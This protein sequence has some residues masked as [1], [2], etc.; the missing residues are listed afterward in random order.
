M[1]PVAAHRLHAALA[2]ALAA[3]AAA[4]SPAEPQSTR[5]P[6]PQHPLITEPMQTPSGAR[7]PARKKVVRKGA[8][9]RGAPK[10]VAPVTPASATPAGAPAS[11]GAPESPAAP[12]TPADPAAAPAPDPL[13]VALELPGNA[14]FKAW[15]E[16]GHEF[17]AP[18][19]VRS[20]MPFNEWTDDSNCI[21]R[22]EGD[23]KFMKPGCKPILVQLRASVDRAYGEALEAHFGFPACAMEGIRC[24]EQNGGCAAVE[25][26][27][28]QLSAQHGIAV[29]PDR[30]S[31]D[32]QWILDRSV[33]QLRDAA[34]AIVRAHYGTVSRATPRQRLEA[35]TSF[36]QNAVPY[37]PVKGTRDDLVRDG[38]MR[39]GL[40]TPIATLF[41]G[42]DCDSKA[43]LLACLVR[44]VDEDMPLSLVYC[45]DED[46]PHMVLAAGCARNADEQS[47]AIDGRAQVVIETTSDWD[48]GHLGSGIDLAEAEVVGLR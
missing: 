43:L 46:R 5:S 3:A 42:G 13:A 47:V 18:R 21:S 41:E 22:R 8:V 9:T 11:P 30:I 12:G 29:T 44:A 23:T 6:G 27:V 33:D 38:K 7:S 31:P 10:S 4:T 34:E 28:T 17:V 16:S 48:I 20:Y 39:C 2:L 32:H 1:S 45:A 14:D 25:Q 15:Y 26:A 35:L 40:R 24:T 36:V 37:R 19:P